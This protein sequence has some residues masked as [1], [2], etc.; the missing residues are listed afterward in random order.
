MI[1]AG[2]LVRAAVGV[3]GGRLA[4]L[5]LT[6]VRVTP[7][8][9]DG[10]VV[11]SA[12]V[13]YTLSSSA[14]VTAELIDP[15]G[16]SSTLFSQSRGAGAQS[17]VFTP[18]GLVDGNYTIRLSARDVVGR[19]A[20]VSVPVVVSREVLSFS[21]DSK[22]VSP[23]GD[24]RRDGVAFRFVLAQPAAVSLS[25]ETAIFSFPFFSSPLLMPGAQS[26]AF[27]GVASDGSIPPDGLRVGAVALSLPLVI[28]RVPPTVVLVSLSPLKLRTAERVTV[29][30]TV[31]GRLVRGSRGPGVFA[32]GKPVPIRTLRAVVRDAAGN[33]SAPLMYPRK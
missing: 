22:L 20:Q 27:T 10:S 33:E 5:T 24:G 30:A 11:P 16:T 32:L 28:D 25:L 4:A 31:N 21:A 8:V 19:Q 26:V 15:Q 29:I 6:D 7:P 12:T 3:L 13:S 2:S 14:T 17:F 1:S 23:N 18:V 9:L